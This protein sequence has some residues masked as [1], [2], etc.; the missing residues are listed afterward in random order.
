[1]PDAALDACGAARSGEPGGGL[2]S[3]PEPLLRWGLPC[4]GGWSQRRRWGGAELPVEDEAEVEAAGAP[5]AKTA[6]E[7]LKARGQM[8]V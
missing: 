8:E 1:V 2:Y 5:P 6:V 4:A 3:P 7:V